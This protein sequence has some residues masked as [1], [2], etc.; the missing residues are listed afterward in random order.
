[1]KREVSQEIGWLTTLAIYGCLASQIH[2]LRN[3]LKFSLP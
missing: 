3:P 2:R 1:M